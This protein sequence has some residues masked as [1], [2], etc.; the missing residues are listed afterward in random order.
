MRART[1]KRKHNDCTSHLLLRKVT[2]RSNNT[3]RILAFAVFLHFHSSSFTGLHSN[4]L[5]AS[6]PG[7]SA[8]ERHLQT[9]RWLQRPLS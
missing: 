1:C 2:C 3:A 6:A 9:R 5:G 4:F 7:T 8:I